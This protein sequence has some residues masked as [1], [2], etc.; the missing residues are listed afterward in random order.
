MS[1]NSDFAIENGVLVQYNGPGGDVVI[2]EGVTEIG[3]SAF[4]SRTD[5]TSVVIPEGVT[6]IADYAFLMCKGLENIIIPEGITVIGVAAFYACTGLVC[7]TIP[8][9]VVKIEESAFGNCENLAAINL[10]E[11]LLTIGDQVFSY[12]KKLSH[13]TLPESVTEIGNQAF[14]ACT[15]LEKFRFPAGVKKLGTR[16]FSCCEK[17]E[18]LEVD[19]KNSRFCVMDGL[20]LSKN[21][22][23]V[24]MCLDNKTGVCHVPSGVTTIAWYAFFGCEYLTEIVL[25]E[26]VTTVNTCAFSCC[27]SLETLILPEKLKQLSDGICEGCKA[28]KQIRIPDTVTRIGKSAFERCGTIGAI[29]LPPLLKTLEKEAFKGCKNLTEVSIPEKVAEVSANTFEGCTLRLVHV[30]GTSTKISP[31]AFSGSEPAIIAPNLPLAAVPTDLKAQAIIGFLNH[32][33]QF[34]EKTRAEY[35]K[36][37]K[38]QRKKLWTNPSILAVICREQYITAKDIGYYVEESAKLGNSELTAMLLEYRSQNIPQE[39]IDK[40]GKMKL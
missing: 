5:L 14:Y 1:G 36:Y 11:G 33:D 26:T 16:V 18:T 39:D 17:L 19:R 27:S 23:T 35:F 24:E 28:L 3:V 4:S 32:Q 8:K 9:S 37:I 21:K 13:V 29:T 6:S 15:S 20:I 7:V 10:S 31:K 2:P 40:A 25:P 30:E 22:K 38:N 12:C 34:S